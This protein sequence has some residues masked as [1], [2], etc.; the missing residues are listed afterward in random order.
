[1]Y[2]HT[3]TYTCAH[4]YTNIY[5]CTYIHKRTCAQVFFKEIFLNILDSSSSS[6]LHKRM[7]LGALAEVCSDAQTIV[8]I[9]VNYDCYM[10]AANIFEQ[11]VSLLCKT[12][13]TNAQSSAAAV[14][15][16]GFLISLFQLICSNHVRRITVCDVGNVTL[17]ARRAFM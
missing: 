9:Y 1:M 3:Q 6:N 13:Q 17:G 5:V 7:V 4:T 8:D 2:I 11:L 16:G 15:V 14:E 10:S 12:A